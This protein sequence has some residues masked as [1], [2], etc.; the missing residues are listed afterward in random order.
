MWLAGPYEVRSGWLI[1]R[2][3][4]AVIGD[5]KD[6]LYGLT[7]HG[8]VPVTTAEDALARYGIPPEATRPW[9]VSV[10]AFRIEQDMVIPWTGSVADKAVAILGLEGRPM[11]GEELVARIGGKAH[12]RNLSNQLGSDP[13]VKRTGV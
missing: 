7:A 6:I 13:R 3:A 9:I 10:S 2:P 8:P 1:H 11:S 5:T 4:L 12:T